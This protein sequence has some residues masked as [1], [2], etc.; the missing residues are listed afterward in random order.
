MTSESAFI[1]VVGNA[2]IETKRENVPILVMLSVNSDA[3]KLI[4]MADEGP[5][6]NAAP[7]MVVYSKPMASRA[8]GLGENEIGA[9]VERPWDADA[10]APSVKPDAV[11]LY[12]TVG[13][14]LLGDPEKSKPVAE[15]KIEAIEASPI[16]CHGIAT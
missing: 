11:R 3:P 2:D 7:K 10:N 14:A 12:G 15:E 4:T 6:S 9:I 8:I 13:R 5:P 16:N 1:G